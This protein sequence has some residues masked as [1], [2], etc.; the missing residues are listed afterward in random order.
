MNWPG[1]TYLVI[2]HLLTKVYNFNNKRFSILHNTNVAAKIIACAT[3][4]SFNT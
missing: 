4:K 2:K 1:G 3:K